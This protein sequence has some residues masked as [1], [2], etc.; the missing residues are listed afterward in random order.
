MS[1]KNN[2]KR[3]LFILFVLLLS[4]GTIRAREY[5]ISVVGDDTNKGTA[6]APFIAL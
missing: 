3:M 4:S 6:K 2:T 1:I 5:H